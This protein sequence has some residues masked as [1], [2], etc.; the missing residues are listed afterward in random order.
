MIVPDANLLLHA[1][2]SE[3]PHW[4]RARRW[5]SECLNG[6]TPIGLTP[7]VVFAFLRIST[8]GRVFRN[9]LSLDEAVAEVATWYSRQVVV[10]LLP[11]REHHRA[12]IALLRSSGSSGGNLVTDAQIAALA[13]AHGAIVHTADHDFQRF[14]KLRCRFP[15]E[16]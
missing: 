2:D 6:N 4:E 14:P 12:V 8:T 13:L 11:D 16:K 3:S 10:S 5:W 15:L 9:P 7:P 1:Y